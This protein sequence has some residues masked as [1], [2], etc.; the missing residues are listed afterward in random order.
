MHIITHSLTHSLT[1]LLIPVATSMF[2]CFLCVYVLYCRE[3]EQL[4]R[5]GTFNAMK[6][7]ER[8][9]ELEQLKKQSGA[10]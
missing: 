6:Q 1:Y 7:A 4:R 8:G 10:K 3:E 9:A 5:L 2:D